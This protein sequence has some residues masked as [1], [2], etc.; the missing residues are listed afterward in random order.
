M[1]SLRLPAL[2]LIAIG[3]AVV[4][5]T[6]SELTHSTRPATAPSAS[7]AMATTATTV[8]A[9]NIPVSPTRAAWR[10]LT[11]TLSTNAPAAAARSPKPSRAD[12]PAPTATATLEPMTGTGV[13]IV[14]RAVGA[15]SSIKSYHFLAWGADNDPLAIEGDVTNSQPPREVYT[16]TEHKD[17]M[18]TQ[19]TLMI[20]GD[21][22]WDYK[23]GQWV[24]HPMSFLDPVVLSSTYNFVLDH[25]TI[26]DNMGNTDLN[27]RPVYHLA[28]SQTDNSFY[29][30]D[31]W[32]DRA[33]YYLYLVRARS[34]D[35]NNRTVYMVEFSRFNDPAIK[36]EPPTR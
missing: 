17:G 10:A 6:G 2:V 30:Y 21:S 16:Y 7:P 31:A 25:I 26:A 3:V 34:D 18:R 28:L 33:T 12:M 9:T 1:K 27:G 14:K 22:A 5:S 32:I 4:L 23:N 36:I 24:T 20:I 8:P 15:I 35:G 19:R 11:A 13:P 29:S